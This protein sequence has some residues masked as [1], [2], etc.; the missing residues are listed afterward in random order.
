[1]FTFTPSGT[2]STS[3]LTSPV[4]AAAS[5]RRVTVTLRVVVAPG[6]RLTC[7]GSAATT[8]GTGSPTPATWNTVGRC[9][10]SSSPGNWY[11]SIG[12]ATRSTGWLATIAAP[13]TRSGKPCLGASG[14]AVSVI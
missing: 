9:R 6:A 8:N 12:S 3:R 7:R 4:A 2:F 13:T 5:G 14:A 10:R 11:V 1:A